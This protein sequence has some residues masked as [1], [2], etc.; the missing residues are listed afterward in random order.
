MKHYR[1]RGRFIGRR[2]LKGQKTAA[3][4]PDVVS[5]SVV[6]T[7]TMDYWRRTGGVS[8][9]LPYVY[10]KSS[11]GFE[12]VGER[13]GHAPHYVAK[14]KQECLQSQL[15]N[16]NRHRPGEACHRLSFLGGYT[17]GSELPV[18][19][20]TW[21]PTTVSN[22]SHTISRTATYSSTSD[23]AT[24]DS[25]FPCAIWLRRLTT[26][27][28]VSAPCLPPSFWATTG[29]HSL[30]PIEVIN[31]SISPLPGLAKPLMWRSGSII[32]VPGKHG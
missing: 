25:R 24:E 11:S 2:V 13:E 20:A 32:R 7:R 12:R 14:F 21:C 19:E 3:Q 15:P 6:L 5:Q 1:D 27:L 16:C 10:L 23:R 29:Q 30:T 28:T 17:Q 22:W 31:Q 8:I 26:A 9:V 4:D 18:H